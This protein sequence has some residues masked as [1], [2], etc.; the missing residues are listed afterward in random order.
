MTEIENQA[1]VV[2]LTGCVFAYFIASYILDL[3]RSPGSGYMKFPK[4]AFSA[5]LFG[6]STPIF[7]SEI[8]GFIDTA[9]NYFANPWNWRFDVQSLSAGALRIRVI[10]TVAALVGIIFSI[11]QIWASRRR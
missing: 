11:D 9:Q 4:R 5:V 10:I 6:V 7:L 2:V 1:T 3:R 8:I